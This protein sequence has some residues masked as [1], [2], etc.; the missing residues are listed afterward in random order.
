MARNALPTTVNK[1]HLTSEEKQKRK[2]VEDRFKVGEIADYNPVGLSAKGKRIFKL[3]VESVP[4]EV[5]CKVDG[6]TIEV[7]ADAI[8]NMR[9]CRE[10]IKKEGLIVGKNDQ[11]NSET[12]LE[13]SGKKQLTNGE[14]HKAIGIYQKYSEIAR[15][16]LADLGLNPVARAKIANEAITKSKS[17]K[18][19]AS[20]IFDDD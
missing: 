2:D 13:T 14:P 17:S 11:K 8:D 15:K 19:T 9:K 3:L 4:K 5:L 7:A 16:Y 6:Y 12:A 18:V 10:I 1:R 20:S